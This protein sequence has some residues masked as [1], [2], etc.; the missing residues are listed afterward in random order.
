MAR[1]PSA[2]S[3]G[4]VLV[5]IGVYV[6]FGASD[7]NFATLNN[8]YA[9]IE[10]C[11]LLG[12]VTLGLSATMIAGE[13]DFSVGSVAAV[14]GIIT[15]R[16]ADLGFLPAI[17]VAMIPA[18]IFGALQG[19]AIARL[20]INSLVFTI[21]TMIAIRGLTFIVADQKSWTLDISQLVYA[22]LVTHRIGIFSPFSLTTIAAFIMAGLVLASVRYAREIYAIGGGRNEAIGAGIAAQ[23][24]LMLAFTA[25]AGLAGLAGALTSMKSGSA[26]PYAFDAI[27]LYGVTAALIGGV[28]L[29]GGKGNALGVA[30]GV[31]TLRFLIS[32]MSGRGAPLYFEILATGALLVAFLVMELVTDQQRRDSMVLSVRRLLLRPSRSPA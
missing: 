25:S 27:M 29:Y 15:I 2:S 3:I 18:I 6:A 12:L 7:P 20:K 32:G 21:G 4:R 23:R 5:A 22:D 13:L 11:A 26:S 16:M 1:R 9:I 8:L 17:I 10:G 31:V 28:S 19:L 24:P 30:I 14:T